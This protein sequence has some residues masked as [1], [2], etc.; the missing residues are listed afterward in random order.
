MDTD[1]TGSHLSVIL[2][3]TPSNWHY[4]AGAG[5]SLDTAIPQL[6]TFFN[7]HIALKHE[8][9]LAVYG[10][11]PNK[12]VLLYSSHDPVVNPPQADSNTFPP[13][14]VVDTTITSRIKKEF[15]LL[16]ESPEETPSDIVNS[17]TKALCFINR[18]TAPPPSASIENKPA[19]NQFPDPR[20]LILSISP[21]LSTSYVSIMNAI[22]AAQKLKVTIDVF[23]MHGS[24]NV[25]LQQAA[26][27]TGGAY[28]SILASSEQ[29]GKPPTLL[30]YLM[31]AALPPPS[32]RTTL[33]VP[34][35]DSIDL[36]AAC[37]CHKDI[38][39]IGFVCSV[40]LSIFCSPIPVCSTCK[41]RFP[42][43]T[44]QR[45][46]ASKPMKATPSRTNGTK[47]KPAPR[48]QIPPTN[49]GLPNSNSISGGLP[50]SNSIGR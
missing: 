13:F 35:L 48:P 19:Q 27:L 50:N 33:S 14:K 28:I 30:Q 8:N 12:S 39:D 2:D 23:Q 46:N 42:M 43:K 11:L 21:D 15:E 20:I 18:I 7:A 22:F 32:V 47:P 4:S 36:R 29:E 17:V 10:A 45:L 16:G 6:L 49:G 41:T 26:H 44:L 40:C 31:M 3:L 37:F 5:L 38:V 25:F 1:T 9:S 24:D 34:S